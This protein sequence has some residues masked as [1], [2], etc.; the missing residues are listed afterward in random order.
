MSCE[1][2]GGPEVKKNSSIDLI[3]S[4]DY[5]ER[6]KSLKSMFYNYSSISSALIVLVKSPDLNI[7]TTKREAKNIGDAMYRVDRDF[8][9][10]YGIDNADG[11]ILSASL[12]IIDAEMNI[13]ITVDDC[14]TAIKFTDHPIP[15]CSLCYFD[16]FIDLKFKD[17]PSNPMLIYGY[18]DIRH[19]GEINTIVGSNLYSD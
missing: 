11:N 18:L 14:K 7:V 2:S 8:D 4:L 17:K 15:I 5:I 16:I 19:R 12:Y 9:L 10:F 3:M 13:K 1:E 6:I